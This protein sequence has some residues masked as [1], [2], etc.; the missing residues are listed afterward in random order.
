VSRLAAFAQSL[1]T[2]EE[3]QSLPELG[4]TLLAYGGFTL[5]EDPAEGRRLLGRARARSSAGSAP[6]AG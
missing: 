1:Q 4:Q 2:F 5:D 6:S 3:I